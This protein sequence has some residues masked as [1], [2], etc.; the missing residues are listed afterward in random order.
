MATQPLPLDQRPYRERHRSIVWPTILI[1]FGLLFLA[2]NMGLV[3]GD[4][5]WSLWQLW[6]LLLVAI[7][8]DLIFNRSI[9]GGLIGAALVLV[10]GA[11]LV[12]GFTFIGQ[13]PYYT[14]RGSASADGA[15]S[16]AA[17]EQVSQDLGPARQATVDLRHGAGRLT[18]SALPAESNQ[19]IQAE[20]GRAEN[21][22][23]ERS[24]EQNN[25]RATILLR[26][27]YDGNR[28]WP[29]NVGPSSG[30][31]DW[32]V[33]L[34]PLVATDLRAETGAG[35]MDLDLSSLNVRSARLN[36]GAGS[37][38]ITVPQAGKSSI[39][40]KAGAASVD[41]TVPEGVAARI[42]VKNGI[43]SVSVDQGRFPKVGSSTYQSPN[44]GTATN[45]ADITI[46]AGVSS[47]SVH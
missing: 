40:V 27:R 38:R 41:V 15:F 8:V 4:V 20:L 28:F 14:L 36:T 30:R 7:G 16:P 19:L 35:E 9:W 31:L 39:E 25:D 29:G 3:R 37:A 2:Q 47:V 10:L 13:P 33:Q 11:A 21:A 23:I 22:A 44:Y 1:G 32:N 43:G 26:D 18:M 46:E 12:L 17:I 34:S 5:W 24:V 45:R 42:S 6:P